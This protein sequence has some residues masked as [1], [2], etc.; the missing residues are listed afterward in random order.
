M[1]SHDFASYFSCNCLTTNIASAYPYPAYNQT[2]LRAVKK[3]KKG[4]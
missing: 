1:L 3:G 2:R 4:S